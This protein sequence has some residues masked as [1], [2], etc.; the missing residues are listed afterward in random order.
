MHEASAVKL[1]DRALD[2]IEAAEAVGDGVQRP[3]YLGD[4]QL[5]RMLIEQEGQDRQLGLG[6]LGCGHE[7]SALGAIRRVIAGH[8]S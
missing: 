3:L 5:G 6:V 1:A 8:G 2:G 4:L 7:G